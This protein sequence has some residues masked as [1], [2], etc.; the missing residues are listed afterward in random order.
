MPHDFPLAVYDAVNTK[1]A[2]FQPRHPYEWALWAGGWNG[3]GYRF[4][5]CVNASE[6]FTRSI[7]QHPSPPGM[8][9]FFQEDALFSFFVDGYSAIESFAFGLHA[10][11][12]MLRPAAFPVSMP[13]QLRTINPRSTSTRLNS[14]Y[15]GTLIAARLQTLVADPEYERWGG[16]RNILAHRAQPAR[17]YSVELSAST[18]GPGNSSVG[19]TEWQMVNLTLDEQTTSIRRQ[20]LAANLTACIE[21]TS[22]FVNANFP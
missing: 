2:T 11:G 22:D 10:L 12:A 15:P 9:R 20:W 16:V 4:R 21:A 14:Q 6:R 8:E 19:A 13:G 7:T 17:Q 18:G 1:V 3:L 5:A